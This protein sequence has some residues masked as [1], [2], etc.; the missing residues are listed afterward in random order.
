MFAKLFDASKDIYSLINRYLSDDD[1][2]VI[3]IAI[4]KTDLINWI[5]VDGT[6]TDEHSLKE[7]NS[8][9][10]YLRVFR[11]VY[12]KTFIKKSIWSN[13]KFSIYCAKHN[14]VKLLKYWYEFHVR[15]KQICLWSADTLA[16]AAK[17]GNLDII[18]YA[19]AQGCRN[20]PSVISNAVYSNI[21]V[22]EWL[23][24][25]K[26][27]IGEYAY[28]KAGCKGDIEIVECL[29]KYMDIYTPTSHLEEVI[30]GAVKSNQTK[31]LKYLWTE[32]TN[33]YYK[34]LI[35]DTQLYNHICTEAI[36]CEHLDVLKL[37]YELKG[38][39]PIRFL[40]NAP[41]LSNKEI[42]DWFHKINS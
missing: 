12:S 18:K 2:K 37:L 1:K 21:D 7:S 23:C 35:D 36:E 6:P 26:F 3:F 25:N 38:Y 30:W 41:K 33:N 16:V 17:Y 27:T 15:N 19:H 24:V 40:N 14:Y 11:R 34:T 22:V 28:F 13:Y 32:S 29:E 39:M 42:I 31:L 8:I 9:N 20:D 4:T 5:E 10:Y